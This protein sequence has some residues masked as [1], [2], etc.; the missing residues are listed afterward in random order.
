MNKK[1]SLTRSI[2][3]EKR[4]MKTILPSI[5]EILLI[6]NKINKKRINDQ[7]YLWTILCNNFDL[8]DTLNVIIRVDDN[9]YKYSK[10]AVENNCPEIAVVLITTVIEHRL[11]VFYREQLRNKLSSDE[12]TEVIRNNI[13]AKTGY[14]FHLATGHE[15]PNNLKNRIKKLFELRNSIVHYKAV[16][17]NINEI[18]K[19]G[20]YAVINDI[21]KI[22]LNKILKLPA[23]VNTELELIQKKI[24]PLFKQSKNIA[25]VMLKKNKSFKNIKSVP[26]M[27]FNADS[28]SESIKIPI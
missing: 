2:K 7:K 3:I 23:E 12:T 25:T 24:D 10:K 19:S 14:L 28:A 18:E 11:N 1:F 9:F 26:S 17:S 16:T 8:L 22:G 27:R 21:N 13:N 6:K 20:Y 5:L 4:L 15:F